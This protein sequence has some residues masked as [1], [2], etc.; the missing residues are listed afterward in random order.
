M[1]TG[2]L[3]GQPI[4]AISTSTCV[5][6]ALP[7]LVPNLKR[8]CVPNRKR[9][10]RQKSR[11]LKRNN[12]FSLTTC[13]ILFPSRSPSQSQNPSQT[14]IS[15]PAWLNL[16]QDQR[17]RHAKSVLSWQAFVTQK[18]CTSAGCARTSIV[19]KPIIRRSGKPVHAL[20][21]VPEVSHS[22]TGED[23]G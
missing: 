15:T 6:I 23:R 16:G 19:V 10:R 20:N 12:H 18:R 2:I 4:T 1:V 7:L 11:R 13:L 3:P 17:V 14:G 21:N 8:L 22:M 9:R 5:D